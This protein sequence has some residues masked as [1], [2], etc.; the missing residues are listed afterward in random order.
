MIASGLTYRSLV[1]NNAFSAAFDLSF[2]NVTGQAQIGFSG[3]SN[4]Y[5]FDFIS[6]KMF[7]NEGRYFYSYQPNEYFSLSTNFSGTAYDY[8]VNNEFY[9]YSGTKADFNVENFYLD[10]TG[11]NI[12]NSITIN[13]NKPSLTL[14]SPSSFETGQNVTGYL[15]TNSTNGVKLFTG[16]FED[17]SSFEFLSLPSDYITSANSGEVVFRQKENSLGNFTTAIN[18]NTNAGTYDQNVEITAVEASYLNYT[19]EYSED[20]TTSSGS[21]EWYG[22]LSQASDASGVLK[23][24]QTSFTYSYDTNSTSLEPSTLP[25]AI[26]FSYY[27]GTTGD[28]G[29]LSDVLV[30]SGGNGYISSPAVTFQ[31][32]GASTAASGSAELGTS[33]SN[34]DQVNN[35]DITSRGAGYTSAPSVVFSGGT[36]ILN[37]RTPSTATATAS[38]AVFEKSFTG[39]FNLYTGVNN[40]YV[41]FRDNGLTSASG[42][43]DS[44]SYDKFNSQLQIKIEYLTT[45]DTDNLVGLLSISGVNNNI[46]NTYI[47]GVK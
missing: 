46:I 42:Y 38:V 14:S 32:G 13:S 31:G 27:T 15:I 28:Y 21:A 1:K 22:G 19:F 45:F 23:T 10:P 2:S 33:I 35:I 37:N 20:T 24:A 30:T 34:Y 9:T 36:G 12:N 26:S 16:S 41:N 17:L 5:K 3:N 18:L 47:T 25:L 43:Y 7:D 29:L 4:T 44:I 40:N 39:A 8:A 11:V 6:G